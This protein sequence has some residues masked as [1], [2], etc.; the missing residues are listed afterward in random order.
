MYFSKSYKK[1]YSYSDDYDYQDYNDYDKEYKNYDDKYDDSYKDDNY[2]DDNYRNGSEYD[3]EQ[4][5][6]EE[7]N[8][9]KNY[10]DKYYYNDEYNE[11]NKY[12][13]YNKETEN[14]L[15][16]DVDDDLAEYFSDAHIFSSK[17]QS[18]KKRNKRIIYKV[19]DKI[20]VLINKIQNKGQILFGPYDI[21]KKQYYQIEL[22]DGN[23]IE[24]DEKHISYQ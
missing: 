7:Y 22:A 2:K 13:S 20:M 5:Y 21:N 18:N 8:N 1:N 23:I 19:D 3:E 10:N 12:A 24:A 9:L 4:Y 17:K 14:D 6:N 11:N 15:S 16:K